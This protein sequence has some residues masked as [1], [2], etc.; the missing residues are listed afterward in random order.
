MET[1]R[2]GSLGLSL[3]AA[4]LNVVILEAL[5]I[6]PKSLASLRRDGASPPTT[7]MRRHLRAL[8]R[9]SAVERR[10]GGPDGAVFG[11]TPAGHGLLDVATVL[12]GWLAAGPEGALDLGSADAERA[13]TVLV[14]G[15]SAGIAR[16]LAAGPHSLGELDRVIRS[17]GLSSLERRLTAMRLAGLLE[18][19]PGPGRA[20]CHQPTPWLRE[21]IAPLAAAARWERVN[22]PA[23]TSPISR[24]DVEAAFLLTAPLV[25]LPRQLEGA[26]RLA[27]EVRPGGGKHAG[28]LVTVSRGRISSCVTSIQGRAQNWV[29]GAP[30]TWLRAVID[31]EPEN[32]EVGGDEGLILAL[33]G[34][35]HL[36]L[37]GSRAR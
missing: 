34:G 10:R 33:L 21:A 27:V 17:A 30:P 11:L 3:L 26:C 5:A 37:F 35:F 7:T 12:R 18:R 22:Q 8:T 23:G 31:G 13:V 2:A 20:L 24:L 4:P 32:L 9:A 16:V 1:A 6:R 29:S 25:R 15:W 28:V 19:V 36:A 14:D